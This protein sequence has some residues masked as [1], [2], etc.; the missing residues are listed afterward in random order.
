MVEDVVLEFA[1]QFDDM[2]INAQLVTGDDYHEGMKLMLVKL[3]VKDYTTEAIIDDITDALVKS[4]APDVSVYGEFANTSIYNCPYESVEC[5]YEFLKYMAESID[6]RAYIDDFYGACQY[7]GQ[8]IEVA[9]SWKYDQIAVAI[10]K[11][12]LIMNIFA[13][14]IEKM[15]KFIRIAASKKDAASMKK[16]SQASLMLER[17][18]HKLFAYDVE[19]ETEMKQLEAV[20][21]AFKK[22]VLYIKELKRIAEAKD[23]HLD[24]GAI[25]DL[26]DRYIDAKRN[27]LLDIVD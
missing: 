21:P 7:G 13:I 10:A 15:N 8:F 22:D 25:K 1:R 17:L 3:N 2:P 5:A 14:A 6:R 24:I 18:R 16:L 4:V 11:N 23:G 27:N 12:H 19:K 9:D 20:K 26:L